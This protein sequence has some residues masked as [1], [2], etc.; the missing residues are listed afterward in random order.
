MEKNS[1][2][3]I[4]TDMGHH[5]ELSFKLKKSFLQWQ[6]KQNAMYGISLVM[7]YVTAKPQIC[8]VD[9]NTKIYFIQEV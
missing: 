7:F 3:K 9:P 8:T 6:K 1:W 2:L 5:E 4:T